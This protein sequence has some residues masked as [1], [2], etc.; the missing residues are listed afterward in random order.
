MLAQ[1]NIL[2]AVTE[3]NAAYAGTRKATKEVMEKRN[4]VIQ[5]LLR[6]YDA[7]NELLIRCVEGVEFYTKL[8]TIVSD[9]LQR[10]RSICKVSAEELV[11][12]IPLV[13]EKIFS[14]IPTKM[15]L[16]SC[17][18]VNKF[19]NTEARTFIR[20]H[21]R[22]TPRTDSFT[23]KG[24]LL[25]A[26]GSCLL[27]CEFLPR[28]EQLC[29]Q[30]EENG[31]VV[32]F[33]CLYAEFGYKCPDDSMIN[34]MNW[35]NLATVLQIKHFVAD[36]KCSDCDLHQPLLTLLRHMSSELQ[37]LEMNSLYA[38]EHRLQ[39]IPDWVPNF[40]KLEKL[41]ISGRLWEEDVSDEE[42]PESERKEILSWLLKDAPILEKIIA[43]DLQSL[44]LLP[45]NVMRFVKLED[46]FENRLRH[47]QDLSLLLSV[48]TEG[49]AVNHLWIYE[50]P[51]NVEHTRGDLVEDEI[52]DVNLRQQFDCA[53][54]QRI[55]QSGQDTLKSIDIIGAYPLAHLCQPECCRATQ[56]YESKG[57][58]D[59]RC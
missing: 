18:L 3:A 55:L 45:E 16:R 48:S 22:C 33:N 43:K 26:S 10:V 35:E 23:V 21:R 50:P 2:Q 19:W 38:L 47:R 11:L 13:L 17:S 5:D 31:R 12:G 57:Q 42:F 20:N 34:G 1:N 44:S 9:L 54:K 15:L 52:L 59:R 46:K 41:R 49:F 6:S 32:P 14:S 56:T 8:D 4:Q 36:S 58:L 40:R 25:P 29:R 27:A 28:L 37:S 7:Y 53:V 24:V 51:S 30:I 39:G